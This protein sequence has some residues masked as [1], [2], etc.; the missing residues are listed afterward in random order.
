[1]DVEAFAGFVTDVLVVVVRA[2]KRT[3]LSCFVFHFSAGKK[4]I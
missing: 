4:R 1:M 2:G 3:R